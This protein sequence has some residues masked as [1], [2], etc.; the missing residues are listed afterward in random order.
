MNGWTP[1]ILKP[2]PWTDPARKNSNDP[3]CGVSGGCCH[4]KGKTAIFLDS[5]YMPAILDRVYGRSKNADLDQAMERVC[6]FEKMLTNE[7][8]LILKFWLHLSKEEQKKRF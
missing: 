5:W 6:R 3:I 4:Q 1:A 7:G 8:A 2:S